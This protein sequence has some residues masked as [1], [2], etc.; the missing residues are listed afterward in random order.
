ML[1]NGFRIYLNL[2][3]VKYLPCSVPEVKEVAPTSVDDMLN[4]IYAIDPVTHLP[5]GALSMYLS[6]KTNQQVREFIEKNI[7]VE[8]DNGE[9]DYPSSIREDILK[10][11]SEFIAKTSR[12]RYESREDYE[13]RVEQYFND[14]EKQKDYNKKLAWIQKKYGKK[15][16]VRS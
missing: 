6:D 13:A 16:E 1:V 11:D 4:L 3:K 8:H 5:G 2:G 9:H 12:N 7:L 14:I 15:D 10:L